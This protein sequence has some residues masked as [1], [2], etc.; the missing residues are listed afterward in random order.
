M[1]TTSGYGAPRELIMRRVR[2]ENRTIAVPNA[3]R[4][5]RSATGDLRSGQKCGLSCRPLRWPGRQLRLDQLLR[6]FFGGLRREYPT[7]LF[8]Q[9]NR[10]PGNSDA[11]LADV[12]RFR[13]RRDFLGHWR[14]GRRLFAGNRCVLVF[15]CLRG[16]FIHNRL[17]GVVPGTEHRLR[18]HWCEPSNHGLLW[19]FLHARSLGL[20]SELAFR[21]FQRPSDSHGRA[22]AK[23]D[24]RVG[25][26]F[27]DPACGSGRWA[28]LLPDAR[29][30][31]DRRCGTNGTAIP[32]RA[33]ARHA[34]EFQRPHTRLHNP[35]VPRP[36]ACASNAAG[37]N[38]D[39][40]DYQS[41]DS[42]PMLPHGRTP[43]R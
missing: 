12:A 42:P 2:L 8:L 5:N 1:R 19:F 10:L 11:R 32:C 25:T 22:G 24:S 17:C 6:L 31:T 39:K 18:G 7:R 38:G 37:E 36:A 35:T 30:F 4:R 40:A 14:L 27:A 16:L 21:T 41:T 3:P 33:D 23:T 13:R 34:C 9:C 43:H 15:F 26:R 20:R 29:L 28:L